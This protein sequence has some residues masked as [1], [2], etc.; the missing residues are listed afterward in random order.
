MGE[1]RA[2]NAED[3]VRFLGPEPMDNE[4]IAMLALASIGWAV[5]F[6]EMALKVYLFSRSVRQLFESQSDKRLKGV[7][8][9]G[10]DLTSYMADMGLDEKIGPN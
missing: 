1:C 6:G 9:A 10:V 7:I 5:A 3:E 4:D 8:F 2:L